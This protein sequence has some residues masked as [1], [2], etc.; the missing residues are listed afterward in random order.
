MPSDLTDVPLQARPP[1]VSPPRPRRGTAHSASEH[2]SFAKHHR[3]HV[4]RHHVRPKDKN[5][6]KDGDQDKG[7]EENSILITNSNLQP[8][9]SLTGV[10]T[11]TRSENVTPAQSK[12][13]SRRTSLLGL[14]SDPD[15]AMA[16][17]RVEGK[18]SK[19][20]ELAEEREKGVLRAAFVPPFSRTITPGWRYIQASANTERK[21]ENY[22]MSWAI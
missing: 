18:S 14:N 9:F 4:H 13:A 17:W 21:L 7:N 6:G 5:K 22:A 2:S 10:D 15:G 20:V 19:E 11:G 3:P 12:S 8:T 1:V 16:G